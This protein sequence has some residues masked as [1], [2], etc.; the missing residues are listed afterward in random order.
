MQKKLHQLSFIFRIC[1]KIYM[2]RK[3]KEQPKFSTD[4]Q[5][6]NMASATIP[7]HFRYSYIVI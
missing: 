6:N 5:E 4:Y 2:P 1:K 3:L 7:L